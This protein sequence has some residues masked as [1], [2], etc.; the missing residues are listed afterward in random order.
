MNNNLYIKKMQQMEATVADFRLNS[1]QLMALEKKVSKMQKESE[2]HNIVFQMKGLEEY[3]KREVL[4]L[5]NR[6]TYLEVQFKDDQ[7]NKSNRP[8]SA[9]K[10]LLNSRSNSSVNVK[11]L[12]PVNC[13]GCYDTPGVFDT[14]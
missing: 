3:I 14:P 5:G 13:I 7:K 10:T 9:S 2:L 1:D 12:F 6:V 4:I 11:K 8:T